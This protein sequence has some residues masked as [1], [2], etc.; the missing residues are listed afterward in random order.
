MILKWIGCVADINNDFIQVINSDFE[1]KE[2][3]KQFG[4]DESLNE[5]KCFLVDTNTSDIY[6]VHACVPTPHELVYK[7]IKEDKF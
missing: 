5:F 2:L 1:I 4:N 6:G 3:K 7:I